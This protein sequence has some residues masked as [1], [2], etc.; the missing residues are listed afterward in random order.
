MPSPFIIIIIIV[1]S[2]SRLF[3]Y[4][5]HLNEDHILRIITVCRSTVEQKKC[6]FTETG[7]NNKWT[8]NEGTV[9]GFNVLFN[10]IWQSDSFFFIMTLSVN[11]AEKNHD[12]K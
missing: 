9:N 5:C 7:Q 3:V 4:N 6:M 12:K 11:S 2:L 1:I 10:C 8:Q